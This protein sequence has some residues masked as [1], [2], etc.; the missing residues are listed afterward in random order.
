MF[1]H[2]GRGMSLEDSFLLAKAEE[3]HRQPFLDEIARRRC[4]EGAHSKTQ[5]GGTVRR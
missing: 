2:N 4:E 1:A 3:S 5:A